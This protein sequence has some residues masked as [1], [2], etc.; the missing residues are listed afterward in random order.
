MVLDVLPRGEMAAAA[1]ELVRNARELFRLP[2]S[3]QTARDLA[4][5]HLNSRL[6]LPINAVL[7]A[8]RA[9]L[10]LGDLAGEEGLR[11]PAEDLNLLADGAVVLLVELRAHNLALLDRDYHICVKDTRGRP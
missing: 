11:L 6:P 9:E 4:A 5:H 3:E 8:E 1:A 2:G 7:E 10:V